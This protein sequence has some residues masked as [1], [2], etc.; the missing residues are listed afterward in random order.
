MADA[1]RGAAAPILPAALAA[2]PQTP[3]TAVPEP[4]ELLQELSGWM[5]ASGYGDDHPW[6]MAIAASLAVHGGASTAAQD[7]AS[8]ASNAAKT[9]S[10]LF[11][12]LAGRADDLRMLLLDVIAG[13]QSSIGSATSVASHIGWLCDLA[14]V[15]HGGEAWLQGG[16]EEWF[17][18]PRTAGALCDARKATGSDGDAA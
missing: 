8:P 7:E 18:A 5:Q 1:S 14:C 3:T 13:S 12:D 4:R 17:L 16:A 6:R 9:V 10:Y 2:S 15:A 11:N